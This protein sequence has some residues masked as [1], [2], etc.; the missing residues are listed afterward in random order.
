L[1]DASL[2]IPHSLFALAFSKFLKWLS[3]VLLES[4]CIGRVEREKIDVM[5]DAAPLERS[6]AS[7]QR[8]RRSRVVGEGECVAAC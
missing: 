4:L 5:V 6:S 8:A 3:K 7:W 1:S 2:A